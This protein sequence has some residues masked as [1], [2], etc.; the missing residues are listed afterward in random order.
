MITF[1]FHTNFISFSMNVLFCSRIQFKIPHCIYSPFLLG[2][3]WS[4][5]IS[6]FPCL[7]WPWQFPRVQVRCS[8]RISPSPT[9]L[10]SHSQTLVFSPGKEY[11]ISE[12][13][14]QDIISRGGSSFLWGGG[15]CFSVFNNFYEF[16]F[17]DLLLLYFPLII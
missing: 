11:R 10:F 16:P 5:I 2:L 7:S 3:L 9:L 17:V 15:Y 6:D 8:C 14:S 12:V 13:P 4:R 1:C